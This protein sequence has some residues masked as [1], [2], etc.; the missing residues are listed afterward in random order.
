MTS[1]ITTNDIFTLSDLYFNRKFALYTHLYN[2]FNKLLDEDIK[3]YLEYNDHTFFEKITKNKVFKYKFKYDNIRIKEPTLENNI[4]P[5]FPSDARNRNLTYS[6]KLIAKVT[7]IEEIIDI[8]T[9][10]KIVNVIG[11]PEDN[12]PIAYLPIMLRS[13]YCTLNL[14]K[15][16]DKTEC[17]YD[18]GG[19]FIV[20]GSEKV[21]LSQDRMVDNKPLVFLKKDSGS[22]F[23][24]AQVNSKSYKP[25]GITQIISIKMKKDGNITIRVPILN[26]VNVF[27]LF[28]ALGIESDKDII[29]FICSDE[30]DY[31]LID[32]IRTGL[33]FSKTD[34]ENIKII[35]QEQ[36]ID[37]LTSKLRVLKNY[38]ETDKTVKANQKRVHILNLLENNFLPHIESGGLINKSYYIGLMINKLL[39]CVI[40]RKPLDDR[41]SYLNKRVDLPGD[42]IMELF[43]QYY[44]QMLN[45]CGNYYKKRVGDTSVPINII[46]QIKP[47]IIEQ[48]IKAA[49]LLGTWPRRSGVAQVLQRL[50]YLQTIAFLRRVDAPSGD[51]STSKL[52]SPRLLH[53]SST[54][55]LCC[56]TGD[57]EVLQGD[58]YSVKKIKDMKNND[59]VI[60]VYKDTLRES[61]SLIKNYFSKFSKKL[62]EIKTISG[63]ILKCSEDHPLLVYTGLNNVM[64]NA[65]N[66]QINDKVIVRHFTKLLNNNYEDNNLLIKLSNQNNNINNEKL[67]FGLKNRN[68]SELN[69]D[70]LKIIARLIGFQPNCINIIE[71]ELVCIFKSKNYENINEIKNDLKI[72]GF[73]ENDDY[74]INFNNKGTNDEFWV[75]YTYNEFPYLLNKLNYNNNIPS[76]ISESNNSIIYKEFLSSYLSNYITIDTCDDKINPLK[77]N[78]IENTHIISKMLNYLKI[79]NYTIDSII[80]IMDNFNNI[81][82]FFDLISFTYNIDKQNN[83]AC[84]IEYIK[85]KL[86]INKLDTL[87][88]DEFK[89]K[90][91]IGQMKCAIP[92]ESIKELELE[93][94]YDFE[95]VSDAHTFIV[96]GFVTSNCTQTPEHAKVGLNKH[97]SL[98]GSVTILEYSQFGLIKN[99]LKKKIINLRDVNPSLVKNYTKVFVN[100]EW[101]GLTDNAIE[102]NKELKKN[103]ENGL[104]N[105]LV[106]IV[107]DILEKEIRIYCDGGRLFRPVL[108]VE[109]NK[110]KLNKELISKISLNKSDQTKGKITSWEEFL[111]TNPGIIEFIDMEEQPYLMIADNIHKVKEMYDKMN[112]SI[113]LIK[114]DNKYN[115]ND[116]QNRYD[117]DMVY[118]KY[119]HSEFH[120]SLLLGEIVSIIPFSCHNAGARNI[121]LYAQAKQGMGIYT[122][123]YRDRLDISYILYHPQRNLVSTKAA[124]YN[125]TEILAA[126]EN[127][128]VAISTFAGFNQEDSA[129][130][131]KSSIERGLF[132]S[133]SLKKEIS[134]IQKNQSTSQDDMFAKPN[135]SKVAGMKHGSYD[136]L[137]EK[138]YVPEETPIVNGDIIIGKISPMPP[139]GN[140]QKVFK[141]NSLPYKSYA[142]GVIDKVYTN[143]VNSEGYPVLKIR[144]RSQREPNI[145]DKFCSRH[146]QK[147]TIGLTL[148]QSDMPFT[149]NGIVPDII[150]NPHCI[151]SRMTLGQIIESILGKSCAI[152]GVEGD[153]TPFDNVDIN[154]IR[155]ELTKLGYSNS[156]KEYLYNG[157]TG[158][159]MLTEIFIGPTYYLRLK[160]LVEDKFHARARGPKT[161]LTHQPPDGR[162]KDG[163]LRLGEMERDSLLAHGLSKFLKEK[164]LDTSDAYSTYVCDLCGLFAQRIL[165]KDNQ[166]YATNND[167]HFCAACKNYTKIS[168]IMIPYAFK[169]VVQEMI[170]MGIVPRI[171]VKK[172]PIEL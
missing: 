117:T 27:I 132:K 112:K 111:L 13:K 151:P 169:L 39:Q 43:K 89:H 101:L 57:S 25:P 49:L 66:L 95:T 4:E 135:P 96:N 67:N 105:P 108:K 152:N 29:N 107:W 106:S 35:N 46:N 140:S 164:L 73:N 21:I 116:I 138:G 54:G 90:Y 160:H 70:K 17:Q 62:Y 64:V 79:D 129:V 5:M 11:Q 56:V 19:Y 74:K 170:A 166:P 158:K 136:K 80:Y 113:E 97:L 31:Q 33:S 38:N 78:E 141:D 91:Y 51:A 115:T 23:Y 93:K 71:N 7:Q 12:I 87:T 126:G 60:S 131:N 68:L 55:F 121:F 148:P 110:I 172:D 137:N 123:N 88:Y 125:N 103:K 48:G 102:L 9:N 8:A 118:V 143:I 153:G 2:S 100:G 159:K 85:Y 26:E 81:N 42:L 76:W 30:N 41:D 22:E 163:G 154:S 130:F 18:P 15:G 37:Y 65:E 161:L 150:L 16:Y 45:N 40:G 83:I 133:M 86:N 63:R 69:I 20:N 119:S 162:Q 24:T 120:P 32:L 168:K 109:D 144:T 122:S 72:L 77:F 82:N 61:P 58:N 28:R 94:V 34:K 145:G 142:P 3:L 75:L 171:R 36:A 147:C 124:K 1:I 52:T 50:T 128:I 92:I 114:K 47:N 14:F 139:A 165:K 84:F 134:Q 156:G 127:A 10:D 44:R 53:Q 149:K 6:G 146:G 59:S 167:L 104:F 98:I 157:M 99:Y 155:N